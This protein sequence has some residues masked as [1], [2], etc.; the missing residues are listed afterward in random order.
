MDLRRAPCRHL[1]PQRFL[2][3]RSE[4]LARSWP[5]QAQGARTLRKRGAGPGLSND[6]RC[7]FGQGTG[8]GACKINAH[9]FRSPLTVAV[10]QRKL[11]FLPPR[12]TRPP[13]VHNV[14]RVPFPVRQSCGRLFCKNRST[15]C[16][17]TL[18][19]GGRGGPGVLETSWSTR[20][21][22]LVATTIPV[23][24]TVGVYFASTGIGD[25]AGT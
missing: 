21:L 24:G 3:G 6:R 19:L 1:P 13:Q 11:A 5:G 25:H 20:R 23:P 18:C 7:V 10:Q 22:R 4:G 2:R 8:S 16:L 14:E 12:T 9:S 15:P 17:S